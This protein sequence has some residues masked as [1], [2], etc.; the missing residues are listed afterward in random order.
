MKMIYETNKNG[1]T[2]E[3]YLDEEEGIFHIHVTKNGQTIKD[4]CCG[5][6]LVKPY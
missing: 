2:T 5:D 6:E 1:I 4:Y 3:L